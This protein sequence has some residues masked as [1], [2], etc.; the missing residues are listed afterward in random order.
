MRIALLAAMF[1]MISLWEYC[2]YFYSQKRLPYAYGFLF[3]TSL[4]WIIVAV[5]LI[6]FFGWLYG[7]IGLLA[8]MF[9]LQ[10]VTHFTLGLL[11][12]LVFGENPLWPIALFLIAVLVAEMEGKLKATDQ[13]RQILREMLEDGNLDAEER[14]RILLNLSKSTSELLREGHRIHRIMSGKF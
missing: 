8:A 5:N 6:R 9:I 7:A 3:Y 14:E 13:Y 12:N 2:S 11:Y 4:Q 10:Y 1:V